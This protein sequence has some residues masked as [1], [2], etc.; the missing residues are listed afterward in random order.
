MQDQLTAASSLLLLRWDI[1]SK[2]LWRSHLDRWRTWTCHDSRRANLGGLTFF[3][4]TSTWKLLCVQ[5]IETS[6]TNR[7]CRLWKVHDQSLMK[8]TNELVRA[9]LFIHS[10]RVTSLRKSGT[11]DITSER[12]T[13]T[14][15]HNNSAIVSFHSWRRGNFEDFNHLNQKAPSIRTLT[16]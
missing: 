3:K 8:L 10:C 4:L 12:V 16:G 7:V 15:S 6:D 11:G 1:L 2:R 13:S 9:S 5:S 14:R